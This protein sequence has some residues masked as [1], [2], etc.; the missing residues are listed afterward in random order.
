M[1][2]PNSKIL[3]IF[4]RMAADKE[5]V[6]LI[7]DHRGIPV[8]YEATAEG[9]QEPSVIFRVNKY[10]CVCLE[11]ERHTF[12][13]SPS[14]PSILKARVADLDIVAGLASLT[15]FESAPETIGRRTIIRVQPKEPV[16]VSITYQG[17]KIRGTLVDVS[18]S[19]VGIYMV[20][21][22]IYNPGMLRKNEQISLTIRLPNEKGIV[23]DIRLAGSILYVNREKGSFRLGINTSPETHA[24]TIIAQYIALRQA[25]IMRELRTLYET[26]YRLRQES[27]QNT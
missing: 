25:E 21:A 19:G 4:A 24:R 17:Q 26:F 9:F 7:N 22:Y 6:R 2:K 12:I 20:S 8:V 10:Q 3:E 23:N 18:S 16:V 27:Q 15:N 13:Q 5:E 11:L 14:L 1:M